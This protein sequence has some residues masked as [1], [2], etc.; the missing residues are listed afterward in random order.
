MV[1]N[2]DAVWTG[3]NPLAELAAAWDDTSMDALLLVAEVQNATGHRGTGDF[4]MD[5][6]GR[7][8]RAKGASGVVYLGAQILRT[9]RLSSVP[10]QVF[11][12]NLLW[13][14]MIAGGRAFGLEHHG[15]WCDVGRPDSI[16]L[17]ESMLRD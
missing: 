5:A 14:Q 6:E 13:D 7:L 9:D 12:L 2:T 15:G 16:A 10:Q 1:L 11:S 8:T 17:A 3:A 4:L